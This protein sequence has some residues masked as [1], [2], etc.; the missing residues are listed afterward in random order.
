M[1]L[2]RLRA[3]RAQALSRP[4]GG[5]A[6]S[7]G[8]GCAQ[9][10]P[11]LR[12]PGRSPRRIGIQRG[13]FRAR[14]RDRGAD[15]VGAGGGRARRRAWR[16]PRKRR[17]YSAT[18]PSGMTGAQVKSASCWRPYPANPGYSSLNVA[19][20]VQ[21]LAYE[22]RLAAHGK[23]HGASRPSPSRAS[24]SWSSSMRTWNALFSKPAFSTPAQQEAHASPAPPLRPRAARE[25]GNQHPAR[26]A[27]VALPSQ[28]NAR[29]ELRVAAPC[30]AWPDSRNL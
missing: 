2:T 3:G 18:R 29:C 16:A 19:A 13:L 30:G 14:A 4:A 11:G 15:G 12:E 10:R 27:Q 6:G 9:E 23:E 8:V 28:A 24:R 5:L 25:R 22:L 1:G 7:R 21:V 17:S 20:A 26:A